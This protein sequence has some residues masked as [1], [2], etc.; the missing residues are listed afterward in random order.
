MVCPAYY[1][2]RPENAELLIIE[3]ITRIIGVL[4]IVEIIVYSLLTR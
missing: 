3:Y 4:F 1:F 2:P